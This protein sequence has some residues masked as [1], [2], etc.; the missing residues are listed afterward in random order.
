MENICASV[1]YIRDTNFCNNNTIKN[2]INTSIVTN[3]Q[4]KTQF[5]LHNDS[6]HLD[7]SINIRGLLEKYSTF[8]Y[9]NT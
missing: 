8:F 6:V 7:T 1:A 5:Y 9:A 4:N 3:V 2:H